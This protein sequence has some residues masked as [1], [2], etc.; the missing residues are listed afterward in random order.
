MRRDLLELLLCPACEKDDWHLEPAK[1]GE[2]DI[3]EEGWLTCGH[4]GARYTIEAGIL[5]LLPQPGESI[6]RERAGWERFLE[7][8]SEEL[9]DSWILA[10]PRI[11]GQVSRNSQSVAHW[12]RQADNFERLLERLDLTGTERVLEL[13]AGRCWASARLSRLGCQ[14]VAL[15]VVRAKE[16]GGLE[17]GGVYLD[18]GTPYFDRVLAS[19]EKLPL[20]ARSFDLILSLASIHHSALLR[21]VVEGCSRV[22]RAGGRLALTSEPCVRLFKEKRVRN[23]E[24][25]AGINEHVYD[26]LDYQRAFRG[27]G[28]QPTF[29]LPGA[30]VAMLDGDEEAPES[31]RV[32]SL[33]FG[34]TRRLWSRATVRRAL[35]SQPANL[36][37]LLFL[38]YGLTAVVRKPMETER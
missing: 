36:A 29:Y 27:S 19:M 1:T 9:E 14:V 15:D 18:H 8:A 3:V 2:L 4:C 6:L 22:L 26:I 21:Q 13:G 17:T 10:L 11:D 33:L 35:E 20:R 38:E 5:D 31:G 16:A 7:D 23:Q 34:L 37:G 28:L 32:R 25:E 12:G 30:L 24:T